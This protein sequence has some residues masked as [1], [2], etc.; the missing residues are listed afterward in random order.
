MERPCCDSLGS[1]GMGGWA[2]LCGYS[3]LHGRP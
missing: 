2:G 1:E 3:L